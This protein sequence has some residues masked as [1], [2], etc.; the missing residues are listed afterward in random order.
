MEGSVIVLDDL[1]TKH[2][3]SMVTIW[4][5]WGWEMKRRESRSLAREGR[6][7]E[8]QRTDHPESQMPKGRASDIAAEAT[9]ASVERWLETKT[10]R[11]GS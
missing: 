7:P 9:R 11:G 6:Q 4:R 1:D 10:G 8:P 2:G 3:G 5:Q